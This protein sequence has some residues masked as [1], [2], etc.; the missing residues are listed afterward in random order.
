MGLLAMAAVV[1]NVEK[2]ISP[3]TITG[4]AEGLKHVTILET[5]FALVALLLLGMAVGLHALRLVIQRSGMNSD[6][7][8]FVFAARFVRVLWWIVAALSLV[9]VVKHAI[10]DDLPALLNFVW[11]GPVVPVA[12]YNVAVDLG[13][14]EHS[15]DGA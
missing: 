4:V 5:A 3:W 7:P 2:P 11:L 13:I 12:I 1:K 8:P 15:V 9:I 6:G 14:V 10:I